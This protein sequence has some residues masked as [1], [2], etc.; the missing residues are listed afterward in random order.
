MRI[1]NLVSATIA[2]N[3]SGAGSL[4][5][6]NLGSPTPLATN[7]TITIDVTMKVVGQGNPANNTATVDFATVR[8]RQSRANIF[9][10]RR[11]DHGFGV[12][13]RLRL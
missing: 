3:G 13:Q 5:W 12:H 9:Q 8:F 11:R 2:P 1:I 4:L 6:T 7:A 10:H